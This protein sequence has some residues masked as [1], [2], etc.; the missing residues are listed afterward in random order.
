V[1]GPAQSTARAPA[2]TEEDWGDEGMELVG[3]PAREEAACEL[4]AAFDEQ[5]DD[6][7][8]REKPK[9]AHDVEPALGRERH[10][11]DLDPERDE[12][13]FR[14]GRRVRSAEHE[15]WNL[16]RGLRDARIRAQPKVRVEDDAQRALAGQIADGQPRVVGHGGSDSDRDRV[17]A[18][19]EQVDLRARVRPRDP[20]R[21]PGSRGDASVEGKRELDR[22]VGQPERDVLRPRKNLK[23]RRRLAHPERDFDARGAERLDAF[24]F[25]VRVGVAT[26]DD[27][28]RDLRRDDRLGARRRAPVMVARLERDVERRALGARTGGAQRSDLRMIDARTFVMTRCDELASTHDDRADVWIRRRPPVLR[29]DEREIHEAL[30]VGETGIRRRWC[31]RAFRRAHGAPRE[32]WSISVRSSSMSRNCR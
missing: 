25:H 15:R 3:E 13:R 19:A 16:A 9:H 23:A 20:F 24:A 11:H 29:V 10:A 5:G 4:G 14:L 31:R 17:G 30:V 12:H 2:R 1:S 26:S 6:S 32:S 8:L 21:G 22:H 7:S 28:A 18:R 27:D